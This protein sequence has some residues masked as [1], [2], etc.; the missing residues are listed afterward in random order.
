[1]IP[2]S[3]VCLQVIPMAGNGPVVAQTLKIAAMYSA[4]SKWRNVSISP[5]GRTYINGVSTF[6]IV[7]LN[8]HKARVAIVIPGTSISV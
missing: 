1:M 2:I 6:A 7:Y 8:G 5:R 3:R 4:S